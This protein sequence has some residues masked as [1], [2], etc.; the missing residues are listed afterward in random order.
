[1]ATQQSTRPGG[2]VK[3]GAARRGRQTPEYV[4]WMAMK[5]RCANPRTRDYELYGGRG[6]R[7]CDRWLESFES[8]LADV[9]RRPSPKHSLDRHPNKDGNYEP[10]NVRWAT[11]SE[12]N[13]NKRTTHFLTYDGVTLCVTDWAKRLGMSDS[14]LCRRVKRWGVERAITAPVVIKKR[15][16]RWLKSE[17]DF[18]P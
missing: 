5:A 10:G 17:S 8:F 12:Q 14:N 7:V 4:A 9:G 15:N 1:M 6:V 18:C 11:M 2:Q 13:R 3:H 16:R